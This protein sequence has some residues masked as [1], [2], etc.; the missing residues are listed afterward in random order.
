MKE[1]AVT[2]TCILGAIRSYGV[3]TQEVLGRVPPLKNRFDA[4][5]HHHCLGVI[6]GHSV[7]YYIQCYMFHPLNTAGG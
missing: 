1:G 4:I 7:I 5:L 2:I 6:L 3:Q